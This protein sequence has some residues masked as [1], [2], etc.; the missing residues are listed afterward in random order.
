LETYDNTVIENQ[1]KEIKPSRPIYKPKKAFAL[2]EDEDEQY[3]SFDDSVVDYTTS[4][5][6]AIL[7]DGN[8]TDAMVSRQINSV[9][10]APRP[11][12]D[13]R[14]KLIPRP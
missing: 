14:P 1:K 4:A 7:Q 6:A 5:T 11:I 8:T 9:T 12:Y 2:E 13:P 3:M 10:S